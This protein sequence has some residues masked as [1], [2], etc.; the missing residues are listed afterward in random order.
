MAEPKLVTIAEFTFA[1]QAEVARLAL[2]E[3]GIQCILLDSNQAGHSLGAI[4][5]VRLQVF[6]P[7]ER[8]AKEILVEQELYQYE[9]GTGE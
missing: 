7:D 2:E 3:E 4:V 5:P 9:D 6:E 8:F 1:H